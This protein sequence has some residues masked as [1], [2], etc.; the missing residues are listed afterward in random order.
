MNK[1]L[2]VL[3]IDG[4]LVNSKKEITQATLNALLD[5]QK[6]GH[7]IAL[8]S[9]RPYPGMKQYV[10]K[11][12]LEQYGGY[13]LAFNGGMVVEC[14]TGKTMF[15]KAIPNRYLKPIYDY[16]IAHNIG[17]VTYQDNKVLTGTEFDEYMEFEARLNF[18][19]LCKLDDFCG[20]IDFD[21]VKCLLTAPVEYAQA[22]EKE[23]AELL[24]PELN[25]FR[26]EPFFIEITVKGVDKAQSIQRLLGLLGMQR[27]D[28][29]CCG[30]GFNDLTMVQYGGVGVAMGNAQQ[31]VKDAADYITAS[32]DEDGLVEVVKH[33]IEG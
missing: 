3:D 4:T 15:Q 28:C 17:M 1:K 20:S 19:E 9:G 13:A 32:C 18:M 11:L 14:A 7:R 27:E 26:S 10:E 31:V 12:Q 6:K 29:I 33:F 21:M 5:I 30:D 16:A 23:L 22:Y 24:M 2:L 25:I 8:A